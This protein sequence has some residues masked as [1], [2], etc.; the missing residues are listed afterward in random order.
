VSSKEEKAT[1]DD[2]G[3]AKWASED[4][5]AVKDRKSAV[6]SLIKPH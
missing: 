5:M 6:S 2:D 4:T 1:G 3:K